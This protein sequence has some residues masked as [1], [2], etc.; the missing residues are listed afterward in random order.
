MHTRNTY[1]DD[2]AVCLNIF[3]YKIIDPVLG[4]IVQCPVLG[5]VLTLL[6]LI[7][8]STGHAIHL[9]KYALQSES[10][11]EHGEYCA[12]IISNSL[13]QEAQGNCLVSRGSEDKIKSEI[14]RK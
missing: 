13:F 3:F 14:K 6:M 2:L 7:D 12:V 4:H 8:N 10:N 11:D 1:H 9:L 5:D